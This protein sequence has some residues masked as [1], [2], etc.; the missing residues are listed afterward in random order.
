ML[1]T[2]D[3]SDHFLKVRNSKR[4]ITQSSQIPESEKIVTETNKRNKTLNPHQQQHRNYLSNDD[5]NFILKNNLVYEL[6]DYKTNYSYKQ[7][8]NLDPE[9]NSLMLS[10]KPI[11]NSKAKCFTYR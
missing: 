9:F 4:Q 1:T 10:N 2:D 11:L 7:S 8:N 5:F 3:I 6:D